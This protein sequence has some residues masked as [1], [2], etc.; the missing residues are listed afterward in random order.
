MDIETA[1]KIP[2]HE[3]LKKAGFT[4]AGKTCYGDWYYSPFHS[5]KTPGVKIDTEQNIWYDINESRGGDAVDFVCSYLQA[6][7]A[8]STISDA[9]RWLENMFA[10]IPVPSVC[11]SEGDDVLL[12]KSIRPLKHIALIK[13]LEDHGIAKEAACRY[14]KEI[15][16]LNEATGKEFPATAIRNEE[17]GYEYRNLY[18]QGV[19]GNRAVSFIRGRMTGQGGIHIFED[20]MDFLSVITQRRGIPLDNDVILLNSA[21]M[22]EATAYMRHYGY[23]YAFTWFTNDEAGKKKSLFFDTFFRGENIRHRPMN[24]YYAPYKTINE[25]HRFSYGL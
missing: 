21:S 1:R 2:L 23:R 17:D 14:L 19:V 10:E 16:L 25:A 22:T 18:R 3:I 11:G 20:F 7:K 5:T 9:L 12:L 24:A 4:P 13:Y 8:A 6:A 15:M